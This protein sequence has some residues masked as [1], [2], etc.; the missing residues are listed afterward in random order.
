MSAKTNAN[1]GG[2]VN[3]GDTFE[4][5][6]PSTFST[7]EK[8]PL[9]AII[10]CDDFEEVAK[11]TL[12]KKTWAFYSSA[13]TDCY[14][15]E[16]NRSFFSRIWFRPR[17]LRNV[18]KIDTTTTILGH[19]VGVPFMVHPA[20]LVKLVHPDGEK[21]IARG[22]SKE[23]VPYCVSSNASYPI[24]EVVSSVPKGQPFFFQLYVNKDRKQSEELLKRVRA[25]G[26]S[27]VFVTVDAPVPGKREADE[28][29]SA[30]PSTN[31]PMS[32]AQAVNDKKG[33]GLGRIM[34]SYIDSSLSWDDMQWLRRC[35]DGKI[36]LKGI[37]SAED[38]KMAADA[39]V[40]GI[41]L[42]NHG[43]RSLDTSPPSIMIL[44][45]CQRRCPEIFERLEVYVDGG[46][47]RG[48]DILKCLCLGA[49]AVGLGRPF[50]Y[51]VN[52]GAEG[53]DHMV[54]ILKDEL[55]TSMKLVGINNL[56]EVHPGLINSLDVDHLVPT[57][58]D[59]PY[60]K[61]SPSKRPK[62]SARL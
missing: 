19:D 37:M 33:G 51:S 57:A 45:E 24:N 43:G 49:K 21:G 17:I 50:L 15:Y 55:E 23:N 48:A 41:V 34:G 59:H 32:G 28:R 1:V 25:A 12:A 36:V 11:N 18:S 8:P 20:A 46:I 53:V 30:D 35:W 6:P 16:R 60:A 5:P 62:R 26:C 52:Y 9:S 13:A 61:W 2:G 54:D 7:Y 10:N 3:R 4:K 31:A 58:A 27:A 38:A 42:S 40:D 39:G 22:L 44:L 14:T 56:S 29:V 47:R